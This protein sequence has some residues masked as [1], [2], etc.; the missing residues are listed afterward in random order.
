MNNILMQK[1]LF[2]LDMDGTIYRGDTLLDGTTAF[3]SHIK[4]IGGKYIFLTNNSS[5]SVNEYIDKLASFGIMSHA[6][7]YFTS[8]NATIMYCKKHPFLR[9]ELSHQEVPQVSA[10]GCT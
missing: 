3:L 6:D 2:L 1:K 9:T 8:T 5:K 7:D 4:S 10:A